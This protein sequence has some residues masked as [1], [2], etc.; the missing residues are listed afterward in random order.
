M[1]RRSILLL[2]AAIAGAALCARLGLWQLD[3]L[4]QR[5]ERNALV[6]SRLEAAPV[7]IT[8]LPRDTALAHFRR[9][10]VAGVPD[11]AHEL[12]L[13]N[14]ASHGSPGVNILTPVRIGRGDTAVLVNRGWVYAPDGSTVDLS[15][16]REGDSLVTSGWVETLVRDASAAPRSS[17]P[18]L[19]RRAD[20]ARVAELVPYPVLPVYLVAAPDPSRAEGAATTRRIAPPALDEGPHL[21]YALQWFSFGAM[22]IGITLFVLWRGARPR[23]PGDDAPAIPP[24]PPLRD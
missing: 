4:E 23:R 9:A 8:E 14:R 18:R 22:A 1:P 6:S 7:P 20:A 5:R 24:A 13:S 3:R 15:R 17:N 12:I 2:L 10:T 11:Y 16:W 21:S 19:L